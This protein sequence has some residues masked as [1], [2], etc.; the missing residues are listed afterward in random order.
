MSSPPFETSPPD[1]TPWLAGNTGT[2][3]VWRFAANAPG[4]HV[5]VT[6]LVHG[7]E[8][9]GAWA[10]RDWLAAGVRPRR[11]TLTLAFANLDAFSRFDPAQPHA[12]RFVHTD[13]NR[14]WGDLPWQ[15]DSAGTG[16]EHQRVLE[17]LPHVNAS[18]WLL[19]LHSMHEPG[20]P[21]AMVGPLE[22][23]A[24]IAADLQ[25]DALLVADQGHR[26]GVRLRDHGRYGDAQ[27]LDAFALLVECGFHGAS[28][29]IDVAR[30][31]MARFL[32]L[33][34]V[35]D[36]GDVPQGWHRAS[37]RQAAP[38]LEVTHAITV[39]PGKAPRFTQAWRCGDLV[40]KAG[41]VIGWNAEVA[42][43]TPYDQCVLVMPTLM[44]ATPGATLVRLA[45][46]RRFA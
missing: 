7:N 37:P 19:D 13:M 9:C 32:T 22:H 42:V 41:T 5:L 33:S 16:S 18:D 23:H 4:R 21:L 45:R 46:T 11:G 12:S 44:H 15:K 27:A 29:S 24:R 8:V 6:A 40:Q 35:V 17:L 14:L 20:P 10:L 28:E 43:S 30:D 25:L 34:G 2:T 39:L 26:A 36:A 31:A 38:L 1:L 3:G